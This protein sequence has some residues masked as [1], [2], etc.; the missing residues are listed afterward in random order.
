[1]KDR[2][3]YCALKSRLYYL[4]CS[5]CDAGKRHICYTTQLDLDEHLKS[6]QELFEIDN[7]KLEELLGVK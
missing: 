6:F 2:T 5:N 4:E 7:G 3:E 1:M